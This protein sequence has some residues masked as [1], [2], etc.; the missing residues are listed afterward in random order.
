LWQDFWYSLHHAA[1]LLPLARMTWS[2]FIAIALLGALVAIIIFIF[3]RSV[4]GAIVM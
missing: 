4:G 2:E 3:Y 1:F